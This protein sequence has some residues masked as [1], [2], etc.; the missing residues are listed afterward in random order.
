ME[1]KNQNFFK[2]DYAIVPGETLRETLDSFGMSRAEL[3]CRTRRPEK[4]ISEIIVG[5]M[6][7][8][9]G[10]ALQ[11]ESALGIPASF[12]VNLER[13]YQKT[14]TRLKEEAQLHQGQQP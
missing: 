13:N 14:L 6:A 1:K 10:T 12:W 9:E 3:A 11:L 8:T 7:I 4:T 5:K 2:P